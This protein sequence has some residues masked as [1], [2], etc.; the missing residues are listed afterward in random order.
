VAIRGIDE[1]K[2]PCETGL[3]R[4]IR[5]V[6]GGERPVYNVRPKTTLNNAERIVVLVVHKKDGYVRTDGKTKT[7]DRISRKIYIKSLHFTHQEECI[8]DGVY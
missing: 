8:D 6:E 7:L 3:G 2:S 1:S 5:R 4:G